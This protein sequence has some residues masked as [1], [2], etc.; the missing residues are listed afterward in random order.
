MKSLARSIVLILLL[1]LALAT[2]GC[3]PRAACWMD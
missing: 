2:A 1:A 3:R